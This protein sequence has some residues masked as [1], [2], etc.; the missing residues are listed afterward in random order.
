MKFINQRDQMDCGSACL[1]MMADHYG[2]KC[3]LLYIREMSSITR[4]GASISGLNDDAEKI[5]FE[6]LSA[7]LDLKTLIDEKDS[8]T[9]CILHWNK[10][11]F[12]V[13]K[14]IYKTRFSKKIDLLYMTQVMEK[15]L[16]RKKNS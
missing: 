7:R 15:L 2:K 8:T 11:H 4:E 16:L 9:P 5:G 14:Q 1:A 13:L 10:N 12:V 6:T 3:S